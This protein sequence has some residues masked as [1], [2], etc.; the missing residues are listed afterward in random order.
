GYPLV[1]KPNDSKGSQ[2]ITILHEPREEAL[3]RAF[4]QAYEVNFNEVLIQNFIKGKDYRVLMLDRKVAA[5][6]HREPA[7]IYGDGF[8]HIELLIQ[9]ENNKP[10]RGE[11]RTTLLS[12]IKV[13]EDT[14][15]Y[16]A[17]Q[18]LSLKYIPK[19]GE[20]IFLSEI[21]SMSAG[22]ESIDYTDDL[23][24]E[25]IR[26]FERMAEA[27]DA[28]VLGLDIRSEDITKVLSPKDYCIIEIN[29]S[30]GFAMHQFPTHGKPRDVAAMIVDL[31]TFQRNYGEE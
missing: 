17:K 9:L 28:P 16:L 22:G 18:G 21:G 23:P 31:I 25:N 1:V 2:G 27:L 8:H 13:T 30:P 24:P 26:L 15:N 7:S 5:V 12:K 19:A 10:D 6:A 11:G 14:T 20:K 29:H 3:E 4:Q